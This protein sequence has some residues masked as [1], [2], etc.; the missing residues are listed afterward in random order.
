MKFKT[1]SMALA[2]CAV[3][4]G[5]QSAAAENVKITLLGLVNGEFCK[6]DRALNFRGPQRNAHPL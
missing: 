4:F 3:A 1:F 6:F 2:A 5:A